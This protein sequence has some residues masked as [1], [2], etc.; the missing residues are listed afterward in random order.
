M[1]STLFLSTVLSL[2]APAAA[3]E[4]PKACEAAAVMQA[5]TQK[6]EYKVVDG[7]AIKKI[8]LLSP[9]DRDDEKYLNELGAEG[10]EL[11]GLGPKIDVDGKP[12][13]RAFY[14]YFKRPAQ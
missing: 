10:W 6:W 5:A 11:V 1:L 13:T 12:A 3:E 2:A 9:P 7:K 4:A 14:Y 8:S